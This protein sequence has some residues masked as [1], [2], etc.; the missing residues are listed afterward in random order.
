ML[1]SQSQV[2]AIDGNVSD[3]A[4]V[5]I[6]S[7]PGVFPYA[8]VHV[9]KDSVYYLLNTD[10]IEGS[11]VKPVGNITAVTYAAS[12]ALFPNPERGMYKQYT[13][14]IGSSPI[15]LNL[16][17]LKSLRTTNVTLVLRLYYLK[18]NKT[19][20][21]NNT[22][23]NFITN[24]MATLRQ[25]GM[26]C[27]LRFA[28]SEVE[29]EADAPLATINQ[30]LDQLK[31][32]LVANKDVIAVMQAGFIG[33]WGEWYYSTNGLTT[34]I[35]KAAVLTKILSTL[36]TNRMIQV[37]TPEYKQTFLGR[38]TA[39]LASEAFNET[40]VARIGHHN[41]AFLASVDDY[42]TY[43]NLA[44]DKAYLN[45]ECLY[46]P[47]GGETC[48]PVTDWAARNATQAQD[49]MRNL[50]WSF[51]HQD[52]YKTILDQWIL[53]GQM[54]NIYRELGY[55]F[56]LKS[57]E[58]TAKVAQGGIFRAKIIIKN[59]GYAPLFNPRGIELV[60]KNGSSIYRVP[61]NIDPRK[62]VPLT[63]NTIETTFVIPLSMLVGNYSLYLNLP[64][65]ETNLNNN[66]NYSIQLANSNVWDAITGYNNLSANVQISAP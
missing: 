5:P 26:K 19:T 42:G 48:P 12:K 24:D 38:T 63:E 66:P 44:A 37:R 46:V 31:P 4:N 28:Y 34:N 15:A 53:E 39:L 7:E 49:E 58:Y 30:H 43:H 18:N 29:T 55:R 60:F 23:L 11:T 62:W 17:N 9:T 32:L 27:I 61:L 65:P 57:G 21:L 59:L 14:Y 13:C 33:A 45:Q 35:N 16:A 51:L 54:D 22:V 40:N 47:I 52:Y 41:D 25:A 2:I 56:Q 64:D 10:T 50:R 1:I 20:S 8:K 3:W 6:L 36:P